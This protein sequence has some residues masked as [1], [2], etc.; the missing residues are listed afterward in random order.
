MVRSA[1]VLLLSLFLG[2]SA[3]GAAA[4]PL[5]VQQPSLS[6]TQIVFVF[7]GDLWTV[8]RAGGSATRLTSSPGLERNPVFSPDGTRIAFTGEY[9]GNVDVFV[10]PASGGVPTRLT[11]HPAADNVLGWTPD[12]RRILFSSGRTASSRYEELFTVPVGGGPEDKLPLPMGYEGSYSPDGTRLAY[13]PVSRAFT[14]WKRYRGGRTTPIWIASLADSRIEAVPRNNSNDVHPMWVG[15]RIYF[16]SDRNGP[17]TLFSYDLGTKKVTQ[18][19]ENHGLD[20]KAAGAG[21]GAIVYEQFGSL[22]LFDLETGKI[23]PVPV[24]VTGDLPEVREHFVKVGRS[25]SNG[26]I[27]PSGARAVFEARG[28]ILTVPAEKGDVRNLTGTS[29]VMD[30]DPAWSPDGTTIAC[31]SDES[32]EYALHLVPQAGGGPVV[33][34]PLGPAPSYYS[35]ARWSPDG[36][37]I[38]FQDAHLALWYVDL[39]TKTPVRVD[40]AEYNSDLTPAWS[41]DS[42]WIAYAKRQA[43]ALSVVY[44]YAVADGATKQVTDGLSDARHAVFDSSGKYLYF[45]AS[46]DIGESLEFDLHAATRPVTRSIYLI[47]LSRDDPSPLAPQS[48]E[49]KPAAAKKA[50]DEPAVAGPGGSAQ[51]GG[52]ATPDVSKGAAAAPPDVK[53][54]FDNILQRVLAVPM[55]PRRYSDLQV[56]RAGVLLAVE[57]PPRG[58]DAPG[59]TVHRYDFEARKAE[60]LLTG[61]SNVKV[62]RNGEKAL[63]QRGDRWFI[64][65]LKPAAPGGPS[66]GSDGALSTDGIEIKVSPRAEWRQM[67]HEVWRLEREFFYDPHFHG[68]DLSAAEKAYAPY[69]E[70]LAARVDLNYLFREMLGELN[71]GHL[72]VNGGDMPEVTRVQTGLLGA[73]YTIEHGR[74]RFARIYDGENWNPHL[75][76]PLTQPGVNVKP[77]EYLLAVNG[78]DVRA[79]DNVYAFFEG[80]AGKMVTLEVGPDPAG[81]GA[82]QVAVVPVAS[83][84]ALRNLAWIEGNRRHVDRATNGRV[85]YVYMPDTAGGGLAAFDRYFFAQVGRDAVIIDERFNGGGMLA[86]DIIEYLQRRR[87]TGVT[88]RDGADTFQPQ[89]AI[90]GPKAMIINGFAGSG[91]DAMPWLFKRAGLGPLVGTRTWGGLVGIGGYPE[92]MDGGSVTAPSIAVWN[93]DTSRWEVENAGI[94]PDVEVELDPALVRQGRDPQLDKAIETVMAALAK[95]PVVVP[96]RPAYPDHH[97]K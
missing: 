79:T 44:L 2:V 73:D 89:G 6:R 58:S 8:P 59:T 1:A 12:G 7:A 54:D 64:A 13:V 40:A 92:L 86:T 84:S 14:A 42:K 94:A 47:V 57:Q 38:A 87:V 31:F 30:W 43:N 77:G 72:Y 74:Y 3:A 80:T 29:A 27:S 34:I 62:A 88:P 69:V 60:V 28:D 51:A 83:E 19:V 49:E 15:D 96:K 5:L 55:P 56:A 93:T 32:G 23:S 48:D 66:G 18:L 52:A 22:N 21:P 61:V 50:G 25:L 70:G 20:L 16:L 90:F 53:I 36:K 68:L 46:T 82:R 63:F 37:K 91:G 24:T 95:N 81:Q 45:T 78:R 10:M 75:L 76:A 85:A 11:W 65:P 41:P 97:K 4:A 33:T 71:V 39:D 67:Y 35:D 17:F 9:D 26:G